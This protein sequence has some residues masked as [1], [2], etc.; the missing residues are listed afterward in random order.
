MIA[1]DLIKKEIKLWS[2]EVLEKPSENF[3]GYAPCPYAKQAW[4]ANKVD[5]VVTEDLG[6]IDRIK[7]HSPP[8]GD[9]VKLVAWTGWE[10]MTEEEFDK[11]MQ[12]ENDNHNG[13]WLIGF[14]PNT[15][16][17][18]QIDEYVY[19][20]APDYALILVQPLKHLQS[21]SKILMKKGYYG[22]HSKE[23]IK[24]VIRRNSI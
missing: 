22:L 20:D 15:E 21:T 4:S 23:E 17:D 1:G 2:S 12:K 9:E 16:E 13:I 5:M 18:E 8:K 14:H 19:S 6:I 3:A 7:T 24:Q 11:W 10:S